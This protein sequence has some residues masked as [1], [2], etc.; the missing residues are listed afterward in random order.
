MSE[1]TQTV[2]ALAWVGVF[3][4]EHGVQKPAQSEAGVI[5]LIPGAV[6]AVFSGPDAVPMQPERA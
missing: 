3:W 4:L 2:R 1:G 5:T 6:W